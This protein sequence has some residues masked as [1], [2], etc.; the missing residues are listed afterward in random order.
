[1]TIRRAMRKPADL[2]ALLGRPI[3]RAVHGAMAEWLG[4]GLQIHARRFDSGSHLHE[5]AFQKD[6]KRAFAR[7][8]VSDISARY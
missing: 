7:P 4:S 5:K 2:T 6:P 1:M 8:R 3:S